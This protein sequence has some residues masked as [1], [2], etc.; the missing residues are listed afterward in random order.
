MNEVGTE[1]AAAKEAV[2][3]A[4]GELGPKLVNIAKQIHQNPELNFEERFASALLASTAGEAGF[5][6]E[7]PVADIETAFRATYRGAR[8]TPTVAFLAEYDALPGVGHACGHNLIG[9]ASLGAAL[10][11]AA[12]VPALP[13]TVQL[14]GTPAEE[15]GGGKILLVDRGVF[16][17]VDAALMFHP[18]N[19]TELWK[20]ALASRIVRIEFFGKAAHA[21]SAP[22]EGVNALDATIQTFNG[23]NA[24]RQHVK[25]SAR[26]HGII[27]HGGEAPNVVPDYSAS[28][29]Y[30]RALDDAYCEKV[31]ER[32]TACAEG[33]AAATGAGV[34]VTTEGVYRTLKTN[35]TLS[36][37]FQGNLEARGWR[38]DETQPFV[39]IGSSDVGNVSHVAPSIHPYL[40]IGPN[41]LLFHSAAFAEAANSKRGYDAML[42]AA[43]ALAHTALDFLLD[44]KLQDRVKA[45]FAAEVG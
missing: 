34:K 29:F 23:I 26:M 11:L 37:A 36:E 22:E 3:R 13:G 24:L 28:L 38:F 20:H 10:G 25:S 33:A 42:D 7:H 21:A 6:V 31:A 44:S 41:S 8:A 12:G 4:V 18:A 40:R 2:T 16:Q 43:V 17:D 35:M 15:G 30:V 5:A 27:T 32:V 39:D 19:T 45:E 9:T 1:I 14:I